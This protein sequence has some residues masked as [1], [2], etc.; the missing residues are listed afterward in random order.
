MP[1]MFRYITDLLLIEKITRCY[2]RRRKEV[3]RFSMML[4]HR[5][6]GRVVRHRVRSAPSP[7]HAADGGE[8]VDQLLQRREL[9]LL[10]QIKLL[11]EN[12]REKWYFKSP[13]KSKRNY[14]NRDY[15]EDYFGS[16]IKKIRLLK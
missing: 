14:I 8:P 3:A 11:K 12:K 5:V 7:A 4:F 10:D 16:R 13:D 15:F 1:N 2:L 9:L 6:V